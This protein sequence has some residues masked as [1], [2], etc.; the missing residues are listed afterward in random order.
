[1]AEYIKSKRRDQFLQAMQL[2]SAVTYKILGWGATDIGIEYE[3][4]EETKKYVTQRGGQTINKGYTL[5]S[6]VEQEV[7]IVDSI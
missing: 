3:A 1:M 5:S 2:G 4:D 7:F 6:S